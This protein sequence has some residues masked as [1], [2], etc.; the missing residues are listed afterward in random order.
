MSEC[1]HVGQMLDV[2]DELM[3]VICWPCEAHGYGV[4]VVWWQCEV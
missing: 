2:H 1:V 4:T 3:H